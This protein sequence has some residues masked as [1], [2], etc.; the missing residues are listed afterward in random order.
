MHNVR[1]VFLNI[2]NL[3]VNR[4]ENQCKE[5]YLPPFVIG[6]I[7]I[8]PYS[9]DNDLLFRYHKYLLCIDAPRDE[10]KKVPGKNVTK[11][12]ITNPKY[13][14]R[15]PKQIQ[16]INVQNSKQ[17]LQTVCCCGFCFGH[18]NFGN[19]NLFS[20]YVAEPLRRVVSNFGFRASNL[21]LS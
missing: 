3:F 2:F 14:Y 8:I 19:L 11:I 4:L 1:K 21:V 12:R 7:R 10:K 15:N 6:W 18:L 16:N 13:E 17:K 5:L 9:H 20:C